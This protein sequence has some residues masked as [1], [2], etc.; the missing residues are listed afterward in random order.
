[1]FLLLVWCKFLKTDMHFTLILDADVCEV[2]TVELSDFLLTF[3]WSAAYSKYRTVFNLSVHI[4]S[5]LGVVH[6]CRRQSVCA[7]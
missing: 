3:H 5:S 6:D 7:N 4:H 2:T 1:M